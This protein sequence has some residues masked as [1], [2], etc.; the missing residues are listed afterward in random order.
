MILCDW[1][2]DELARTRKMI[3]PFVNHQVTVNE[4]GNPVVSY[5]L[6]SFGYDMRIADKW[7]VFVKSRHKY[8]NIKKPDD[9]MI[10]DINSTPSTA[11]HL[12][13]GGFI[14][15]HSV[16]RFKIPRNVMAIVVGKSTYAR[17]GIIVNVTPLEAGWEGHVTIEISNTNTVPVTIYGN[18]GIAQ[19]VFHQGEQPNISY[20]DRNG[21][22]QNQSSEVVTA[23]MKGTGN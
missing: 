6:S 16:E 15:G 4:K 13:V 5:G 18:E 8:Y 11:I 22:Y 17:A 10:V 21:K 12:P 19:V 1:Q 20:N 9:E 7:K 14:L 23:R 2:I 3:D